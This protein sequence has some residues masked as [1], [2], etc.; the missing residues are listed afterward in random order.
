MAPRPHLTRLHCVI[1][2]CLSLT[3]AIWRQAGG[4]PQPLTAPLS[5][6]WVPPLGMATPAVGATAS[7]P[8]PQRPPALKVELAWSTQ[9]AHTSPQLPIALT[10]G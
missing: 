4:P 10:R 9:G 3:L 6:V 7:D 1:L 5:S 8:A 2:V